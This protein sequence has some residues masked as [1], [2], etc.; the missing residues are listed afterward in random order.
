MP[1]RPGR[2]G[3]GG[4]KRRSARCR[5]ASR[6]R[7]R[8]G[9]AHPGAFQQRH[10]AT[11]G[12]SRASRR[13]PQ[14][15][16]AGIG[17]HSP[18][19]H[20]PRAHDRSVLKGAVRCL[21][22]SSL[23]RGP[24]R[25]PLPS[26]VTLP[27]GRAR[28]A[29]RRRP[30]RRRRGRSRRRPSGAADRPRPPPGVRPARR[31]VRDLTEAASSAAASGTWMRTPRSCSRSSKR[32]TGRP[33]ATALPERPSLG[34]GGP[35][36]RGVRARSPGVAIGPDALAA[37]RGWHRGGGGGRRGLLL[38]EVGPMLGN[39]RKAMLETACRKRACHPAW[40]DRGT[41]LYAF[42][43]DRFARPGAAPDAAVTN[44]APRGREP[45]VASPGRPPGAVE[46]P[47]G[48]GAGGPLG[49]V[50]L[51]GSA[52]V[53]SADRS[54][55]SRATS[56]ARRLASRWVSVTAP[57]RTS[58]PT[59]SRAP[60]EGGRAGATPWRRPRPRA[61]ASPVRRREP[62]VRQC[63][64]D[65]T[66][67]PASCA[68][69]SAAAVDGSRD[70]QVAWTQPNGE[71]AP[72]RSIARAPGSRRPGGGAG[73]HPTTM[74]DARSPASSSSTASSAGRRSPASPSGPGT[75]QPRVQQLAACGS[76]RAAWPASGPSPRGPRVRAP[77]AHVLVP[78]LRAH[79]HPVGRHVPGSQP[80]GEEALGV[81]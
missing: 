36:S 30:H 69:R 3:N 62:S 15:R 52:S 41:T 76:W 81:A 44:P 9:P 65:D 64:L 78:P 67:H 54:A 39:D 1:W 74:P 6:S 58:P 22:P 73:G 4:R 59:G 77:L 49:P 48:P 71:P 31:R 33:W 19:V 60:R 25:S 32:R 68:S 45:Q 20:G 29:A 56:S 37:G 8:W 61:P 11:P 70:F 80:R 63:L 17:A 79:R 10:R 40:R 12:K 75:A 14:C 34:A 43:T 57:D 7:G 42:R 26:P 53:A 5:P 16:P 72:S 55:W 24:G 35:A 27:V 13:A 18:S 38:P 28:G 21:M 2:T 50:A 46:V 66:P 23:V 47:S 51:G